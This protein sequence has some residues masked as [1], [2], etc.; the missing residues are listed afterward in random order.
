MRICL[1][2]GRRRLRLRDLWGDVMV[3]SCMFIHCCF[4]RAG[5]GIDGEG[6]EQ[7][8]H[9]RIAAFREISNVSSGLHAE[10]KT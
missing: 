9:E 6:L 1:R 5:F 10:S 7:Y 2:L 8:L 4:C 3:F